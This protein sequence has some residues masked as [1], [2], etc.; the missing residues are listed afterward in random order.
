MKERN[1]EVSIEIDR[2]KWHKP[3]YLGHYDEKATHYEG[4]RARCLKCGKSFVFSAEAQKQAFEVEQ[5]YP[6]W[7]PTLCP[8]CSQEWK[9]LEETI[10]QYEHSWEA[11]R[12]VLARD[13]EFLRKWLALLQEARPYGKKHFESR[14]RM[15]VKTIA[16]SE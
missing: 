3:S 5:R 16:K 2:S 4:L 10:L 15:L 13:R 8:T 1:T 6:C 7:L 14:V 11:N 12:R 9:V